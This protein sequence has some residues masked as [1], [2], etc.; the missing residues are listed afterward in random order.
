[1]PDTKDETATAAN[2]DK[3]AAKPAAG[4]PCDHIWKKLT[5][6]KTAD[7]QNANQRCTKCKK[8]RWSTGA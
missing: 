8:E 7:G 2:G 3:P 5:K 4:E 1:M 6:I